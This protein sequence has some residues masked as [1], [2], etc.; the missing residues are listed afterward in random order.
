MPFQRRN[1]SVQSTGMVYTERV[2]SPDLNL[3]P[4][5]KVLYKLVELMFGFQPLWEVAKQKAREK[6]AGRGGAIGVDQA[7]EV[8]ALEQ[9]VPS[10]EVELEAIQNGDLRYPSYY[11]QPF[12]AYDSGNLCWEAAFQA[13]SAAKLVHAAVMDPENKAMEARGDER[14]RR[15]YSTM[16]QRFMSQ[17]GCPQPRDIVDLGCATGLSTLE[18]QHTFPEADILG[19]DLSPYFL[20]VAKVLQRQRQGEGAREHIEFRHAVAEATGCESCSADLVS[21]C[22]VLHEVPTHGI[23]AIMTEAF[24]L[25][26]PGGTLAIMEMNP[27]SE[28]F[29]RV[30]SNPF[31]YVPFKATEPWLVEYITTN[32][33]GIL[34]EIGFQSILQEPSTP[35]HFTMVA[36]KPEL[37]VAP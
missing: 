13:P 19:L 7:A 12:H 17:L 3:P 15:S 30:F 36:R 10:W 25:L 2:K 29:K 20:A 8:A 32:L 5:S 11:T 27:T 21:A 1:L 6:I 33:L 18:L 14:L 24:R 26:R 35:G 31:A 9:A 34:S 28:R 23:W 37:Q 16:L 22:L 4:Q